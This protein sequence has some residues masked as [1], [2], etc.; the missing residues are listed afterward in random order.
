MGHDLRFVDTHHHFQDVD[1]FSYPWLMD[2]SRPPPL[3]GDLEPIRRSY[4]P[5]DYRA[6]FAGAA[7][8]KSV[9][10]ENGWD[11]RDPVG[12]TRWLD[13][14]RASAPHLAAIVAYADLSA[15]DVEAVLNAHRSASPLLRGI[16]QSLSWHD[17]TSL[18]SCASPDL[19]ADAAWRRGFGLLQGLSLSF[20][21]QIYWPQMKM[22]ARLA[23]DSP[24]TIVIL[25]HM[26]MPIDRSR[27]G[28]QSWQNALRQFAGTPNVYL[29]LSGFGLGAPDWSLSTL[30]PLLEFALETFG[31]GRC[32]VG[33]NFP[34]DRL[35]ADGFAVQ[36]AIA[37]LVAPLTESERSAVLI[38]TARSVYNI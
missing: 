24:N 25:D 29:K 38:N 5:A 26:G 20:D 2:R 1:R 17:T 14:L 13:S 16:R 34:V 27:D 33:T 3:E 18:R 35:F 19:M 37:A 30:L 36:S 32:M 4:L 31:P 6:D 12:E 7:V 21:L 28:I 22:A 9:H 11:R 15:P 23:A 10:V 8:L